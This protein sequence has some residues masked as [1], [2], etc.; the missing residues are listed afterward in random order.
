MGK[1]YLNSFDSIEDK[2]CVSVINYSRN[3]EYLANKPF[4][5]K[6]SMAIIPLL[7]V[8][9]NKWLPITNQL[10]DEL[11]NFKYSKFEIVNMAFENANK[12]FPAHFTSIG[13]FLD[14]V[15]G[16]RKSHRVYNFSLNNESVDLNRVLMV[17][18]EAF[19][20]G[21]ASIFYSHSVLNDLAQTVKNDELY[22]FPISQDFTFCMSAE[23][24]MSE[25]AANKL[26]DELGKELGIPQEK[27][28]CDAVLK[29]NNN[30]GMIHESGIGGT[31]DYDLSIVVDNSLTIKNHR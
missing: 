26:S 4:V 23:G 17:S 19:S 10:I 15:P 25:D 27:R 13:E 28:V 22:L 16:E 31:Y 5:R 6:G 21:A 14:D 29:Y 7:N 8:E 24:F 3:A 30:S 1:L 18:N 11:S 20:F 9:G 12:I 2:L